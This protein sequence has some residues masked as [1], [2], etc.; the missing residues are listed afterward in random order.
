MDV[1]EI[2][3]DLKP[4]VRD[5]VFCEA[6]GRHLGRLKDEGKIEGWRLLR[7]KLGF[8]PPS[9]GEFH[10]LIETRDLAQLEQAFQ[11]VSS[12]AEPVESVH[13]GVNSL[14]TN[15]QAGLSR[16]FPDPHRQY[17]QERF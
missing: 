10:I 3:V 2:W 6:L 9:L 1:Y 17:G 11:D 13:H 8:G 15:F 7:R 5:T 16:D 4:G 12:R 14:V